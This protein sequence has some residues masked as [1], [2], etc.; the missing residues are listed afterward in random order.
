[1]RAGRAPIPVAIRDEEV[2]RFS[3]EVEAAVY[4]CVLE[5]V[6]N[7]VKYARASQVAVRL[8]Q[9]DGQLTFEVTDDGAGF[10]PTTTPRGQGLTNM[11]DRLDA[12]G[13][14][15]TVTSTPGHGTTIM[16][17][18]PTARPAAVPVTA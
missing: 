2:G 11:A 14:T 10:D 16:G 6:Q 17:Q 4:F 9:G 1:A 5:A 15:L 13:G 18:L 12:L 7:A 8:G 3:Q